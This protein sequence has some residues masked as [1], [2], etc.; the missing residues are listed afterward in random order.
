MASLRPRA[1][2]S[3]KKGYQLNLNRFKGVIQAAQEISMPRWSIDLQERTLVALEED[4][5]KRGR[6]S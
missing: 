3:R 2:F 5:M 4:M 1:P 6:E